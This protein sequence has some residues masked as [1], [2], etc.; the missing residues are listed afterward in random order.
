V[1]SCGIRACCRKRRNAADAFDRRARL[2]NLTGD[3]KR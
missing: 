2:G 1:R 3:E